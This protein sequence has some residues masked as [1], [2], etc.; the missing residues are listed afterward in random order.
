[1][2]K[3]VLFFHPAVWW[4]EQRLS[5]EREMAC[6][7]A[8]LA[9]T[10]SPRAYA[11]CLASLA[12][13]SFLRRSAALAQAAVS[14]I[15]QTSLRVAQI[16]DANRPKAAPVRKS[17]VAIVGALACACAAVAWQAPQLIAFRN[18][19]VNTPTQAKRG[20]ER[21]T[22]AAVEMKAP[23][24]A[25]SGKMWGTKAVQVADVRTSRRR[26]KPPR[27]SHDDPVQVASAEPIRPAGRPSQVIEAKA[28]TR[29]VLTTGVVVILVNDPVLGPIP[30]L[31]HFA[32]WQVPAPQHATQPGLPQKQI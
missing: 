21:G 4:V 28:N 24:S 20:P 25:R 22:R 13:K 8:V 29:P 32:V 12:E 2:I 5:L 30:I 23:T 16:L 19:A 15:R 14:R 17:A 27:L 1:V 31:Y 11:E 26:V 6:D 18:Q 3:S 9:E 7:D 10:S